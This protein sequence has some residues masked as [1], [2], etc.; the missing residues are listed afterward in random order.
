MSAGFLYIPRAARQAN[1]SPQLGTLLATG[2]SVCGVT[3][4]TAASPVIKATPADTAVAVANVVA[5]GTAGML[6]FPYLAHAAFDGSSAAGMFLGVSIHDT[7]QVLGSAA[8]YAQVYADDAVLKVAAVTK[9]TRNLFLAG[10]I[11]GLAYQYRDETSSSD[12]STSPPPASSS[13]SAAAAAAAA[14][15]AIQGLATFQQYIPGFVVAFIAASAARSI[16][17]Y[18]LLNNGMAFGVLDS[19]TWK[20]GI[21]FVG[22]DISTAALGTAMAAVG[23][24]TSSQAVS[25]V[26]IKPFLVGGSGALVVGGTGF[27]VVKAIEQAGMLV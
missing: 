2:T 1:L 25:G 7:S 14:P 16:G 12:A 22:N 3:A 21:S 5:F 24:S 10:V 20:S 4:I 17:D 6:A 13:S 27:A 9:L 19:A 15:S 8:T 23:L 11:P 18:T 26:G